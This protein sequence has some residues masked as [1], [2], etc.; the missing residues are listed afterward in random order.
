MHSSDSVADAFMRVFPL[1]KKNL[2]RTEKGTLPLPALAYYPL[3][4]MLSHTG[5]LS[6]SDI[7]KRL[8]SP[9]PNVTALVNRLVESGLVK[10]QP[11]PN[12]RRIIR[13]MITKKGIALRDKYRKIL[14]SVIKTNLK[15][16][17]TADLEKLFQALETTY[18]VL[19][20]GA[21]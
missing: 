4:R 2:L 11:D 17:T 15:H 14:K 13:F 12:D 5:P 19:A 21:Q 1:L 10:R 9:K 18:R 3:L 7:G 8:L 6:M 20:R 16:I